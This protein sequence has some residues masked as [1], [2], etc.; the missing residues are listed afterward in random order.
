MWNLKSKTS[1]LIYKTEILTE[2]K[3]MVT[4]GEGV[5]RDK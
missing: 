4:K 5:E 2:N 3:H 1:K